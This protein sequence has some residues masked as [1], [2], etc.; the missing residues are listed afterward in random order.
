MSLSARLFNLFDTEEPKSIQ[1]LFSFDIYLYVKFQALSLG[2]ENFITDSKL[3]TN[4][5]KRG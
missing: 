2:M 1:L 4:K 3:D 5:S